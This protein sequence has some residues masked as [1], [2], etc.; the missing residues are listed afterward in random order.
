M[1]EE[2]NDVMLKFINRQITNLPLII[3]R[4]TTENEKTFKHRLEIPKLLKY[5]D[6]FLD[7]YSDN[8]FFVLTGLRGVGKTTILYQI[9]EYL[10][11]EKNIPQNQ[12]LYLSCEILNRRFKFDILDVIDEFLK[13]HHNSTLETLDK[14]IFLFIDEAQYDNNWAIA[15]KHIYDITDKAFIIFTGSSA[16]DLEY[17]AD[18][19]RRLLK[20]KIPPL[21]YIHHLSL[22]YGFNNNKLSDALSEL[23]FTGNVEN[24]VRY[25]REII[26]QLYNLEGYNDN[27][28]D[29]YIKSG[30]F[31]FSFS[32]KDPDIIYEQLVE[33]I[34]RI[35][36]QDIPK[37]GNIS[38]EN[39]INAYRTMNYIALEKPDKVS[40]NSIADFLECSSTTIKNILDILEKTQILFHT[41]AY[42]SA[43][44]RYKK[45]RRYF[46]A[47]SSLKHA[48]NQDLDNPIQDI[49]A[50]NGLLLENFVASALHHLKERKKFQIYYDPSSKNKNVDFLIQKGTNKPVPLEVGI[51]KKKTKQIRT[52]MKKYKSEYGIIVSNRTADIEKKEN[53]IFIPPKTFAMM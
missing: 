50:Y 21:T 4:K 41:Q 47:T 20:R 33:V 9:Y 19:A 34:N 46:F 2:K 8:R 45:T 31:P 40:Q 15:G 38:S 53:I 43:G 49:K 35:I 30:G 23:I 29:N 25:E 44:K 24:A 36:S 32:Q 18:G 27:D 6:D 11:K 51:G 13:Y 17:N 28:L 26:P 42:G 22:K 52:S 48:L 1:A 7:G 10:F 5:V 12:M 16:L 37:I 3:N 39:I 14:E